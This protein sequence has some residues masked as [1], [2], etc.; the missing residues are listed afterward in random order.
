MISKEQFIMDLKELL[1]TDSDITL[2]TDLLEINE[3][4]SLSAVEFLVMIE[5]RYGIKA[6][7]FSVAEAV[8]VEDLYKIVSKA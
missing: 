6:E 4:G 5:D 3:W 7:P 8:F 2:D 1:E